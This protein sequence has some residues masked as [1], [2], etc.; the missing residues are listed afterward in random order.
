MADTE[1]KKKYK[2][3]QRLSATEFLTLHPESDATVIEYD[4]SKSGLTASNVQDAIDQIMASGTGVTGVKGNAESTY[5]RRQVNLT[6]ANIGAQPSFTDGSA[7]IATESNNVVTIRQGVT[8]TG[9]KIANSTASNITLGTAAKKTAT[10]SMSSTPSDS[11]ILTEKAVSTILGGYVTNVAYDSTNKKITKTIGGTTSDVVTASTLKTAMALNNVTNNRQIK[12][13][14]TGTT[15]GHIVVFGSDGY[16]VADG[17]KSVSDIVAIAEG[18]TSTYVTNTTQMPSLNVQTDSV[19]VTSFKDKDGN[20]VPLSAFSLGSTVLI[21]NTNVPDRWVSEI[22]STSI[23]LSILE[24]TK[25]DVSGFVEKTTTIAGIDLQDN[26][27]ATELKSALGVSTLE[28]YFK[29]GVANNADKLDGH[30]SSYFATATALGNKQ[31]KITSSNKLSADLISDGT[32]NKVFTATEKTKLSGIAAGAEVNVQSDWSVTDSSSDAFI[33]NK[34]TSMKNPTSLSI[35]VNGGTAV[36]YDGSTQ[37]S[38][39]IDY[40]GKADASKAN[41]VSISSENKPGLYFT[42]NA[43]KSVTLAQDSKYSSAAG[44]IVRDE[45]TAKAQTFRTVAGLSDSNNAKAV[46]FESVAY[47]GQFIT[48][49]ADGYLELTD[50][51]NAADATFLLSENTTKMPT[52]TATP[53]PNNNTQNNNASTANTTLKKATITVKNGKK[54]VSKVTIKRKKKVTNIDK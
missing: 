8:Q 25:V 54:K 36:T 48:I 3:Q 1:T 2:L 19:T 11:N 30:D 28:G 17:G 34:P 26:I 53:T 39:T 49:S 41:Y 50:G 52:S 40:R 7:T 22:T 35:T 20:A 27:T 43:D 12:G 23:T 44:K 42:A 21:T 24:T 37:K 38:V 45:A 47:P 4:S 51:S 5:R 10:T 33:K 6:P 32:T 9:G 14:A 13:L 46:S 29:D 18:K 16:T 15:N 31:D